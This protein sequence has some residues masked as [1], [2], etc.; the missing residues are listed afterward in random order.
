MVCTNTYPLSVK[1]RYGDNYV[2]TDLGYTVFAL[3]DHKGYFMISHGYS[4]LTKCSKITV[5]SPRDFDCNGHYIYLESA[6]MHCIPFHIQITDDLIASCS[7]KKAQPK[8]TF[9][10]MHYVHGTT[11][12]DENGATAD[13]CRIRM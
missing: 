2:K 6:I 8:A 11:L 1:R 3:D 4:D 7:K 13:N 10:A 5:T 12:Y 9:T